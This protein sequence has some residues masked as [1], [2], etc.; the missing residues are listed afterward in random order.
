VSPTSHRLLWLLRHAKT[1]TNPPKGG[2]DPERKLAPRG[3]RD[4]DALGLRLGD[5]GDHLGFKAGELPT[6]VLCST[7]TR[8]TQT[9]ERVLAAMSGPPPVD[10]RRSLY[11]ASPDQVIEELR[12]VDDDVTSVMVVGHN[13]TAHVLA[14]SVVAGADKAGRR[15]VSRHGFPTCALAVYR[16][17]VAR[18]RDVALG[19]GTLV[20]LRFPPY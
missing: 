19:T 17:P 16:L 11:N 15:E 6:L 7:A 20:G 4:A 9:A 14:E 12:T 5:H 3:R 13:P 1:L 18:W 10:H 8:T 2:G